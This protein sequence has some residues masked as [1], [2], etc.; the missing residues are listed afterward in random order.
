MHAVTGLKLDKS[1][2]RI[3]A[4]EEKEK[5]SF[6]ESAIQNAMEANN[7]KGSCLFCS[8][9]KRLVNPITEQQYNHSPA[10]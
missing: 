9:V 8:D 4:Y 3:V 2:R 5:P 7:K 6:I 10:E 1:K